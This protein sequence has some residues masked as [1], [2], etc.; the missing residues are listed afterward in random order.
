MN[1]RSGVFIVHF[2]HISQLF[3]VCLLVID[4]EQVNVTWHAT[5]LLY[6]LK[7]NLICCHKIA[8]NKNKNNKLAL[9]ERC[10]F[11]IKQ[12]LAH[13][14]LKSKLMFNGMDVKVQIN[15]VF[16]F[17]FLTKMN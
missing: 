11:T 6:P 7:S 5:F 3:L 10:I 1:K 17:I 4:F 2:E 13:K 8:K 14:V 16:L 15:F 9:L 12:M